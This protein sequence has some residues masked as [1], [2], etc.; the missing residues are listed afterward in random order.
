MPAVKGALVN[1][2]CLV[3]SV[4]AIFHELPPVRDAGAIV[5]QGGRSL[6]KGTCA[7]YDV[8]MTS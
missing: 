5:G 3:S 6:E 2:Q 8:I 1:S 7:D 4:L